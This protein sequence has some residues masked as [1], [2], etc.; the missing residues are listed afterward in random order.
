MERAD[1]EIPR[2]NRGKIQAEYEDDRDLLIEYISVCS[3]PIE[4]SQ[5]KRVVDLFSIFVSS[6]ALHLRGAD[7]PKDIDAMTQDFADDLQAV[8]PVLRQFSEEVDREEG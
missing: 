4:V 5:F 2:I 8:A 3:N 6:F 1:D 7:H